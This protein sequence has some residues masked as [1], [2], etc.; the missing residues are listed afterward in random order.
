MTKNLRHMSTWTVLYDR[1]SQLSCHP[2]LSEQEACAL[3]RDVVA[4]IGSLSA[5]TP[6]AL[7]LQQLMRL[8]E[9]EVS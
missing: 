1:I 5:P 4:E 7:E 6:E 2:V 3:H 9:V 8:N